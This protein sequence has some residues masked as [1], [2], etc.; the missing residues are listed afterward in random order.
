MIPIKAGELARECAG[1]MTSGLTED[2]VF[3]TVSTDSRT[4]PPGALFV[5]LPG[6]Q[7]D[8]R[9]HIEEAI[10]RGAMGI[11]AVPDNKYS[12]IKRIPEDYFHITLIEVDDALRAYQAIAKAARRR[13]SATV[14]AVTG[15]TGKTT[16]KEMIAAVLSSRGKTF[17][18][19][20]NENNEIGLP[21]A[22]LKVDE[23]TQFLVLEMGMRGTGQIAELVAVA[24]PHIGVITNVGVTHYELLG[25]EQGIAEA[26]A[27]LA[28]GLTAKGTL[29]INADDKWSGLMKDKTRARVVTFGTHEAD[30][31]ADG[32]RLDKDARASFTVRAALTGEKISFAVALTIPG[33]HNVANALAAAATGLLLEVEPHGIAAGL[34]AVSSPINRL[35]VIQSSRG[36][37]VIND[38]YNASPTSMEAAIKTL[39][40]TTADRRVAILGDMLE[41]G[42][43]SA[44]AHEAAG[45][46]CAGSGVDFLYAVGERAKG[47]AEA[48]V[49]AGMPTE[50]V[51]IVGTVDSA[52][53]RLGKEL[54]SGDTILVK[55]SRALG[56]ER[57][58][59]C[60]R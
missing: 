43:V 57:I 5:A 49:D 28:E 35:E 30:V 38:S 2:A 36:Y 52:C 60:I 17:A 9:A 50:H 24:R 1:R 7:Y 31:T 26:K 39:A 55:A 42:E 58:V 47:I 14:I 59:E 21:A 53:D 25:S 46:L 12:F 19:P 6:D 8:G 16:T 37:T 23:D 32:I 41:L 34:S 44:V 29:I 22:I 27:E 48:A 33:E 10:D 18:S 40:D 56:F 11:V 13:F 3:D 54:Q 45:R 4:V 51:V 15:S 20:E